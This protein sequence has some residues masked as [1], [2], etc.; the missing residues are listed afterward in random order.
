[1]DF[2]W[3]SCCPNA[4]FMEM[5]FPLPRNASLLP[6]PLP[7]LL[8]F[9]VADAAADVGSAAAFC[10]TGVDDDDATAAAAAAVDHALLPPLPLPIMGGFDDLGAAAPPPPL[11]AAAPPNAGAAPTP[12][13]DDGRRRSGSDA[14]PTLAT[15]REAIR[16]NASADSSDAGT[17][18]DAL[19]GGGPS[20][21]TSRRRG[22]FA[23]L[24]VTPLPSAAADTA[25]GMEDVGGADTAAEAVAP[26]VAVAAAPSDPV[27]GTGCDNDNDDDDDGTEGGGARL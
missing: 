17:A 5:D 25:T 23:P 21:T 2:R 14:G 11:P 19:P 15:R 7:L 4:D 27:G 18:A 22:G 20:I 8:F 6:P 3:S 12:S 24:T 10:V 9:P 1:M 26:R 13:D 16:F